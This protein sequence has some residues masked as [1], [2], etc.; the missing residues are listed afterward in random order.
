MLYTC[1]YVAICYT[2]SLDP[3]VIKHMIKIGRVDSY[4]SEEDAI[5]RALKRVEV[6]HKFVEKI[7]KTN[8]VGDVSYTLTPK[9]FFLV[10]LTHEDG[11]ENPAKVLEGVCANTPVSARPFGS[12]PGMSRGGLGVS[13]EIVYLENIQDVFKVLAIGLSSFKHAKL[14]GFMVASEPV[15]GAFPLQPSINVAFSQKNL[16]FEAGAVDAPLFQVRT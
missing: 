3:D 5:I 1:F 15:L 10:V 2:L 4:Q 13:D 8:L 7:M 12:F 14:K 11:S 9:G 6:A 16:Q